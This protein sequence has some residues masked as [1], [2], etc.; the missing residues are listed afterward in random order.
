MVPLDTLLKFTTSGATPDAGLTLNAARGAVVPPVGPLATMPVLTGK[1][2]VAL[3]VTV[4][5]RKFERIG[6]RIGNWQLS[7]TEVELP[8][9]A[10]GVNVGAGIGSGGLQ[11]VVL[12]SRW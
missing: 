2:D 9:C 5:P 1:V 7:V 4:P 3:T 12:A 8:S 11:F 10:F 6:V